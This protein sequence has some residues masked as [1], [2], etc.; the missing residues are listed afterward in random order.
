MIVKMFDRL[1]YFDLQKAAQIGMFASGDIMSL[2]LLPSK[3]NPRVKRHQNPNKDSAIDL[4]AK[5]PQKKETERKIEKPKAEETEKKVEKPKIKIKTKTKSG[6]EVELLNIN[7]VSTCKA[8]FNHHKFGK[9]EIECKWG[10]SQGQSGAI[11]QYKGNNIL[12][13]VPKEQFNQVTVDN[14]ISALNRASVNEKKLQKILRDGL[15]NDY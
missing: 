13:T 11:G 14:A 7:K 1:V 5:I 2:P 8:I 12:L 10:S 4:F 9:I 15:S 3:K 6:I